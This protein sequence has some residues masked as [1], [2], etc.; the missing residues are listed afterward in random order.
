MYLILMI[1]LILFRKNDYFQ[2]ILKEN[3]NFNSVSYKPV[4][5]KNEILTIPMTNVNFCQYICKNTPNCDGI[6]YALNNCVLYRHFK[7]PLI[8]DHKEKSYLYL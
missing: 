6:N 7:N 1:I 2:S 8:K 3:G 4:F 5:K